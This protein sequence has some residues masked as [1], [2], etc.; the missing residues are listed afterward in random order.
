MSESPPNNRRW[1][2]SL[3]TMFLAVLLLAIAIGWV[4]SERRFVL[5][6]KALAKEFRDRI[7]PVGYIGPHSNPEPTIPFWRRWMG[8]EPCHAI[9]VPYGA[10]E[11]DFRRAEQFFP[12]AKIYS[13]PSPDELRRYFS[14]PRL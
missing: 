7:G 5:Q 11:Y 12:E 3:R 8:D 2:F 10:P 1:S 4:T 14:P 6:R 13:S 9:D